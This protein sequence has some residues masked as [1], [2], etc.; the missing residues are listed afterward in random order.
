MKTLCLHD[1]LQWPQGSVSFQLVFLFLLCW[2]LCREESARDHTLPLSI[3]L[4]SL[5][6]AYLFLAALHED[7]LNNYHPL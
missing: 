7:D 2:V 6:P 5:I 3:R 4:F 1:P